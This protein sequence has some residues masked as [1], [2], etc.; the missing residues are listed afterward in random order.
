MALAVRDLAANP[1]R[2]MATIQSAIVAYFEFSVTV[3][4]KAM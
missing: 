1:G 3:V 4:Q 2:S